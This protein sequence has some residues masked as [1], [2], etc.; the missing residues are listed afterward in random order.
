MP[1]SPEPML[2]LFL[3]ETQTYREMPTRGKRLR[4]EAW[5]SGTL[6][7][8]IA[9]RGGICCGEDGTFPEEAWQGQGR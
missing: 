2:D 6:V 3:P 4:R 9:L 7:G 1:G 8:P 5:H